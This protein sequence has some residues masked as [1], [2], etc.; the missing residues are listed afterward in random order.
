MSIFSPATHIVIPGLTR[1]PVFFLD[2]CFRRN[3]VLYCDEYRLC[4]APETFCANP[5]FE[6]QISLYFLSLHLGM[7]KTYFLLAYF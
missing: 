4:K 7:G 6:F 5:I 3:D 1:N 2:S